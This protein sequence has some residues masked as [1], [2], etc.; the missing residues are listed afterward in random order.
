M[1]PEAS[2][3]SASNGPRYVGFEGVDLALLFR[4]LDKALGQE[5]KVYERLDE[6]DVEVCTICG[7]RKDLG[8][9]LFDFTLEISD[10]VET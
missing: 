8:S 6:N 3:F 2:P 1:K 5:G 10:C 7:T 4:R 9:C